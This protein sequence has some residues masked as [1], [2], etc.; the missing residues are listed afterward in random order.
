MV[1]FPSSIQDLLLVYIS[2]LDLGKGY[3]Y[4]TVR[5]LA[6][7]EVTECLTLPILER[8]KVD[9]NLVIL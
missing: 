2:S 3:G 4:E 7:V 1:V 5:S 8:I 9:Q 6:V